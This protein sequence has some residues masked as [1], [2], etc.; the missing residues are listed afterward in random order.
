MD[1]WS[2]TGRN[3]PVLRYQYLCGSRYPVHRCLPVEDEPARNLSAKLWLCTSIVQ[4]NGLYLVAQTFQTSQ[5]CMISCFGL[6]WMNY[7]PIPSAG[8]GSTRC[9]CSQ[10]HL[11]GHAWT[12]TCRNT[13]SSPE[14]IIHNAVEG[15][16]S[17]NEGNWPGIPPQKAV[18]GVLPGCW[19]FLR[20]T[21]IWKSERCWHGSKT[22]L[23]QIRLY[24]FNFNSTSS[25]H[26][27]TSHRQRKLSEIS[28]VLFA[29]SVFCLCFKVRSHCCHCGFGGG[30]IKQN[31]HDFPKIGNN[32]IFPDEFIANPKNIQNLIE[33]GYLKPLQAWDIVFGW[34]LR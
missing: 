16:T 5:C 12:T 8:I 30:L 7:L 33:F 29:P 34:K 11:G 15:L 13:C 1:A 3:M 32:H 28:A 25:Q 18:L 17:L 19:F 21:A 10:C 22:T 2:K 24:H 26:H 6:G 20:E 23:L 4:G 27:S 9:F 31:S 14:P